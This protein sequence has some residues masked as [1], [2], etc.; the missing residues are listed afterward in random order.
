M[1]AVRFLPRGVQVEVET[2]TSLLDAAAAA[3]VRIAAP[4][5]G[6]GA[7]GECVN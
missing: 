5:G 7:C 1:V 2:G 6:E 4:C 3:G